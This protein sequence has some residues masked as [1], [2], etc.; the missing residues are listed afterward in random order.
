[1][2][3]PESGDIIGNFLWITITFCNHKNYNYYNYPHQI[4]WLQQI[5]MAEV[6]GLPANPTLRKKNAYGQNPQTKQKNI[7]LRITG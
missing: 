5:V 7:C 1:V 2:K 6:L 4:P 3:F